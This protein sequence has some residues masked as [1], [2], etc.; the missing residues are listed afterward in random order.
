MRLSRFAIALGVA[1]GLL[2]AALSPAGADSDKKL[3]LRAALRSY[4]ALHR[5]DEGITGLS[6]FV[7]NMDNDGG[8]TAV[9]GTTHRGRRGVPVRPAT[10]F[11]MGSN[12]KAFT[13]VLLLQLEAK[14]LLDLDQTVGDWLP[15]YPAWSKVKIRRLLNM[16][17]GIPTYSE[18]PAFM[19]I[20]AIQPRRHF[21]A[22]ELVRFAYPSPDHRLPVNRGYFYS[23]TNYI[24]AG[25]IVEK[26]GRASYKQQ[27]R[28]RILQ[29]LGMTQ[30]YYNPWKLPKP[31][32]SRMAGGYFENPT[33]S[34]YDPD[35][36]TAPLQPLVGMNMQRADLS[37]T[38][39]AGG[40]VSTPRDLAFWVRGLFGGKVLAPR[41]M[42]EL[43]QIVST[44]TGK[45]IRATSA[46][47]PDGFGLG[48]AE[49]FLPG[50]GRIW[51]Y[52]GE[53]LGYRGVYAYYPEDNL[54][55]VVSINSQPPRD[56][57]GALM[58]QMRD[59]FIGD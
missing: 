52:E 35:C 27:L 15:Q 43:K 57:V 23:N 47:D 5:Q 36:S 3:K 55:T 45:P 40:I 37:W 56:H 59:I 17:S 31:V 42:R 51:F 22:D 10:L 32:L 58:T 11:E 48:V 26:A 18:A 46:A 44:R 24:L 53:T 7:A 6:A 29:P 34:E 4:L 41:Q 39:A 49:K 13:S 2:T 38:G 9:V 50:I 33:C 16:T 20:Q 28:E 12:T 25:M 14:G 30:T 8:V 21:T 54:I 1:A 19:Q